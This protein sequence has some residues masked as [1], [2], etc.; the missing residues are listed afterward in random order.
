MAERDLK[1]GS[2]GSMVS[3]RELLRVGTL[4]LPTYAVAPTFFAGVA[5]AATVSSGG[6]DFYISTTG[7]DS[8]AGTLASPWAITAINTKQSAYAGKRLGIIAGTYDVS[9]LMTVNEG[10]A[11]NINGGASSAAQTY[12]GSCDT[13]GNYSLGVS[14]LDAKGASGVYGGGNSNQSGIVGQQFEYGTIPSNKGNWT[15]DGLVFTG[16]SNWA[17][18]VGG[19][20]GTGGNCPNV[21]IQ[22]CL[23]TGG[24]AASTNGTTGR[25][26][27]PLVLYSYNNCL[28]QNCKWLN[29]AGASDNEHFTA[30]YIWGQGGGST[31]A[32]IQN[33]S[34][35]NS[36]GIYV[37]TDNG[38]VT[39]TLIQRCYFDQSAKTPSGGQV[40][41]IMGCSQPTGYGISTT[42]RNNIVYGGSLADCTEQLIL[43]GYDCMHDTFNFYNNTWIAG[44]AFPSQG[45]FGIRMFTQS[46]N[47]GLL[48]CYNNL[49][50]DPSNVITSSYGY[51]DATADGFNV[52]DYNIYGTG[53]LFNSRA[54]GDDVAGTSKTLATWKSATGKEAHSIASGSNPFTS[55]GTSLPALA[56]QVASGSPAYQAGRVGGVSTGAVCNIGAW[57]GTVTQIGSSLVT[58]STGSNIPQAPVLSVS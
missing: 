36:G 15:L 25:N 29:N 50:Y 35:I 55:A 45:G 30:I 38:S 23:F 17:V 43:G 42:V 9:G 37:K 33:C 10:L 16:F 39:G 57:D 11:L 26:L 22:N 44:P 28:V 51:M 12:I 14:T 6:F 32:T 54:A 47:A 2:R 7:N 1:R 19:Y 53:N 56:Y 20:D 34:M 31:G 24:S 4:L 18:W 8:N 21:T 52:L 5:H 3:R 48:N 41:G 40:Q 49:I 46:A 13:S 27:A 58:G